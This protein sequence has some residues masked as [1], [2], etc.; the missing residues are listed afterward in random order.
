MNQNKI[1]VVKELRLSMQAQ[2]NYLAKLPRE[3]Q[4]LLFENEYANLQDTQRDQL[5]RTLF[6]EHYEDVMWFLYEFTAGKSTGPHVISQDGTKYT[7]RNDND[8]YTYLE[9]Q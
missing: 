4:E 1:Q 6:A 7:F 9:T 5:M 8:Y 2:D 3:F